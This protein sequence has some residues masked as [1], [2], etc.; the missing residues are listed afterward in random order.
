MFRNTL[1]RSEPV[2]IMNYST[3][4]NIVGVSRAILCLD[5]KS[6]DQ[7]IPAFAVMP[8]GMWLESES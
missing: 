1:S 6:R 8:Q 5:E 4:P 7:K 3:V 2:E